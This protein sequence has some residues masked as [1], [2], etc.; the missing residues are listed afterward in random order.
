MKGFSPSPTWL[1]TD[2]VR[3]GAVVCCSHSL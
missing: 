1:Q 3:T 2:L